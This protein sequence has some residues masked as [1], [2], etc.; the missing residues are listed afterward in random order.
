MAFSQHDFYDFKKNVP[1]IWKHDNRS[2]GHAFWNAWIL[3][4]TKILMYLKQIFIVCPDVD[5][6]AQ[7][8]MYIHKF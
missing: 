1:F 5:E 6:C 8:L 3:M 7:I 4:Y 2:S